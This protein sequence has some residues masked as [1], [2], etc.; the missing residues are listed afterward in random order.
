M[1]IWKMV[2]V[3]GESI[4]EAEDVCSDNVETNKLLQNRDTICRFRQSS[5]NFAGPSRSLPAKAGKTRLLKS[6][7]VCEVN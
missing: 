7:N 4:G 3:T 6:G 5:L 1:K 2:D